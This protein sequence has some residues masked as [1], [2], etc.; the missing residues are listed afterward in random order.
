MLRF[1]PTRLISLAM[2]ATVC[3]CAHHWGLSNLVSGDLPMRP[4]PMIVPVSDREFVWNQVV[5]AVDDYFKIAREERVR[6]VGGVLTEGQIDTFPTT[7]STWLEPWRRDSTP[8][9]ERLHSTL[10]SVRRQA[11]VR[12]MPVANGYSIEVT[13]LKELEDVN[14]AE[15]STVGAAT[16]RHDGTLVRVETGLET[17]PVTLG[18]IP[19]GRDASLEQQILAEI[20]ARVIRGGR[21]SGI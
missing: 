16:L 15:N 10:Q 1:D 12:V 17:L 11:H 3:G 6:V 18:W 20:Y 5:D 2:L 9:V 7:A 4:N 14:R 21:H 13:V 19:L 8:G